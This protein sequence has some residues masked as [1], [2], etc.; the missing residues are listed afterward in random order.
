MA[1]S[2]AFGS[3]VFDILFGLGFPFML[4]TFSAAKQHRE[5]LFDEP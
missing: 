4:K 1:V 3:N 5:A 2:N